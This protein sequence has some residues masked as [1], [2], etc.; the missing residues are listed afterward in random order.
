MG[1][2]NIYYCKTC[3]YNKKGKPVFRSDSCD[4]KITP[5]AGYEG[6]EFNE[7]NEQE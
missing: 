5:T 6:C 3:Y 1:K 4:G 2:S 7:V